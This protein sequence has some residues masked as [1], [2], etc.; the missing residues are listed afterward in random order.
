MKITKYNN[1]DKNLEETPLHFRLR[2]NHQLL[3]WRSVVTKLGKGVIGQCQE[4]NTIG[5][6]ELSNI[7]CGW[8]LDWRMLGNCQNCTFLLWF[9]CSISIHLKYLL[10][11][12]T[13]ALHVRDLTWAQNT[14]DQRGWWQPIRKLWKGSY[15]GAVLVCLGNHPGG[16]VVGWVGSTRRAPGFNCCNRQPF[17]RRTC[18]SKICSVSAHSG[19]R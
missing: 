8:Y 10:V 4:G 6:L 1:D 14:K 15:L 9:L 18:C 3:K 12:S 2:Q 11:D 16:M 7:R 13:F 5:T 17:Y 19:K